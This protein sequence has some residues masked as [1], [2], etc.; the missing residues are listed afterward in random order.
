MQNDIR[1]GCVKPRRWFGLGNG[2]LNCLSA[3][4]CRPFCSESSDSARWHFHSEWS[5]KTQRRRQPLAS[6]GIRIGIGPLAAALIHRERRA[7]PTF[8]PLVFILRYPAE[9]KPWPAQK[10]RV[11]M[12][13]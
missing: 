13:A 11:E 8:P 7:L 1:P 4:L 5:R 9:Q 3:P 2:D 10:A 12:G 6:L